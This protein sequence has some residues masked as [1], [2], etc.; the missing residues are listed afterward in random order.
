M[1]AL[2]TFQANAF[3]AGAFQVILKMIKRSALLR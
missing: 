1:G 3:Q 2:M